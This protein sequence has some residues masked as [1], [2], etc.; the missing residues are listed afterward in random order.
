MLTLFFF[1][2]STVK[3]KIIH[4]PK[5]S[6]FKLYFIQP[7]SLFLTGNATKHRNAIFIGN[8]QFLVMVAQRYFVCFH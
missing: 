6:S 2:T 8:S 7:K 3:P 1:L 5:I 4:T